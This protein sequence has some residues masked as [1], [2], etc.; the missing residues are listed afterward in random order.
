MGGEDAS[1]GLQER[2]QQFL[3]RLPVSV[4]KGGVV[5]PVRSE[6]KGRLQVTIS[7]LSAPLHTHAVVCFTMVI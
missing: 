1:M 5:V 7:N 2:R 4:L 6:V 3:D